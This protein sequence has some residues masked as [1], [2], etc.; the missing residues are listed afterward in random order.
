ML[1][2]FVKITNYY[3]SKKCAVHFNQSEADKLKFNGER[4]EQKR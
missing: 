3:V 4:K 1:T 2:I